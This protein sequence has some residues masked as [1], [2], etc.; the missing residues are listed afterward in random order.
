M[1]R[2]PFALPELRQ[3]ERTTRMAGL[4]KICSAE[5]D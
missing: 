1:A 3:M 4:S 5:L 2:S